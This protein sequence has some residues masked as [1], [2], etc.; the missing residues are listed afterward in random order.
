[1]TT[2]QRKA[3]RLLH[4]VH[5]IEFLPNGLA[6]LKMDYGWLYL[7]PDGTTHSRQYR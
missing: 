3:I 4:R 7:N 1:M 5:S 6:C 2:E